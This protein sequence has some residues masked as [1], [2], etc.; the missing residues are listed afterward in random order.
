M[1]RPLDIPIIFAMLVLCFI[2]TITFMVKQRFTNSDR[3]LYAEISIDA[4]VVK[5]I[6]LSNNT[7]HYYFKLKPHH[8]EYNV[9]EVDGQ[10]IRDKEDNT[11]DQIAVHTSWISRL[12]QQSICLPHKLIIEI[13]SSNS[14][15]SD[16]P[17]TGMVDP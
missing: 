16:A 12:G 2:P 1:L 8:G 11:P 13:T 6:N 3:V 17:N 14:H 15:S 10:S 9:I 7:K 4:D 5:K